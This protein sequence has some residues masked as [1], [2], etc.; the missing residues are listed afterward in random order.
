MSSELQESELSNPET[1]DQQLGGKVEHETTN[2]QLGGKVYHVITEQEYNRLKNSSNRLVIVD[3][4]A[5]WCGP[6]KAIAPKYEELSKK[7]AEAI[8]M[9]VDIDQLDSL[10]DVKDVRA[11]PSFKF[12]RNNKYLGIFKG[13]NAVGLEDAIKKHFS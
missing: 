8:F 12:F 6:C 3:Y 13:A 7:Y 2:E 11:V 10:S 5:T 4:S 1:T 9:H